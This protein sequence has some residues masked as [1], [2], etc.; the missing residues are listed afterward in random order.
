MQK[1]ISITCAGRLLDLTNFANM[2][3]EH[4]CH[5]WYKT[6]GNPIHQVHPRRRWLLPPPNSPLREYR[7]NASHGKWTG[8]RESER[9]GCRFAAGCELPCDDGLGLRGR[10]YHR[11]GEW[12]GSS[13]PPVF[14]WSAGKIC[15]WLCSLIP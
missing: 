9:A 10:E 11:W 14:Q 6:N 13:N 3:Q 12:R 1:I 2:L 8:R 15:T 7:T 5:K 4:I